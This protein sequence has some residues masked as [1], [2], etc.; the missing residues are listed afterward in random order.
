MYAVDDIR[1]LLQIRSYLIHVLMNPFG[2]GIEWFVFIIHTGLIREAKD[3]LSAA[4]AQGIHVSLQAIQELLGDIALHVV[5]QIV[6]VQ[7]QG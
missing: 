2:G 7:I 6:G 4:F 5:G 3:N 1:M